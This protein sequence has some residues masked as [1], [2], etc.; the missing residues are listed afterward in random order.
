MII[1]STSKGDFSFQSE[2]EVLEFI[3][4]TE[5]ENYEI[6]ISG[7]DAYPCM[8]VCINGKYAA[9]HYFQN[10]IGDMWLSY[11]EENQEEVTFMVSGEKWEPDI[12][13][14]ISVERAFACIREFCAAYE[15]PSC[16]QWQEL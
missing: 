6:W 14:I 7:K 5:K 4:T 13:A 3:Q 16:I 2:D 15:I 9:V 1:V 11:N 10:D 12:H 8:T